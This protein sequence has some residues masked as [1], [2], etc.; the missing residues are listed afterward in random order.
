[1]TEHDIFRALGALD[2]DLIA[3]AAPQKG[4]SA[5]KAALRLAASLAAC[6]AIMILVL[7]IPN[8][9]GYQATDPSADPVFSSISVDIGEN[10]VSYWK[11]NM[12]RPIVDLFSEI[13]AGAVGIPFESEEI[14]GA[15]R[16]TVYE[17]NGEITT[18]LLTEGLLV[19]LN[20]KQAYPVSEAQSQ[21]FNEL[22][23]RKESQS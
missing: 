21:K 10:S 20:Q 13:E 6:L 16:I 19:N 22:L 18:Y 1:M 17:Y 8:F 4:T 2:P 7:N 11:K 5:L 14:A 9:I 12:I 15:Y 23:S 3:D